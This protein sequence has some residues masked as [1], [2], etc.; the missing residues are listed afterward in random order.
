M[1]RSHMS[2]RRSKEAR[3]KM[4]RA[5]RPGGVFERQLEHSQE[6]ADQEYESRFIHRRLVRAIEIE[7]RRWK[8]DVEAILEKD[9]DPVFEYAL[10]CQI[11]NDRMARHWLRN[12]MAQYVSK[13]A[14]YDI[15]LGDLIPLPLRESA[16]FKIDYGAYCA[17]NHPTA[18]N[19]LRI[20]L[21]RLEQ[22]RSQPRGVPGLASGFDNLDRALGGGLSGIVFLG[23]M[24]G[25]GKTSLAMHMTIAALAADSHLAAIIVTPDMLKDECL[26]RLICREAAI[27]RKTFESREQSADTRE[28]IRR[29]IKR[30]RTDVLT[31]ILFADKHSIRESSFIEDL[32]SRSRRLIKASHASRLVIVL[33]YFQ[34]LTLPGDLGAQDPDRYRVDRLYDLQRL[35]ETLD[36]PLGA[37]VL[38][39]SEVRKRDYTRPDLDMEDL[40]GSTRLAYCADAVLL[41]ECPDYVSEGDVVRRTLKVAKARNGNVCSAIP[42]LFHH[43][44]Y[45]FDAAEQS[46]S[47]KL[48]RPTQKYPNPVAGSKKR[49]SR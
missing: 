16:E 38:A 22:R 25:S 34:L 46:P 7:R 49:K 11:G 37:T 48:G 44:H 6:E 3:R 2:S 15:V 12:A 33:D 4:P 43:P 45:R 28:Q 24:A 27:D 31:R 17:G 35:G 18:G 40:L 23:G 9:Q 10:A 30:L 26:A 20:F 42:L 19:D 39:I 29:A 8:G 21:H 41:L 36:N 13:K 5:I 1:R 14:N 47:S 32:H